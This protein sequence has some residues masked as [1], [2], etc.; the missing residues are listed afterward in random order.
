[1]T[2]RT[3]IASREAITVLRP[4]LRRP[5]FTRK[6]LNVSQRIDQTRARSP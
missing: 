1:M 3:A 5:M 6:L 2:R 4:Q